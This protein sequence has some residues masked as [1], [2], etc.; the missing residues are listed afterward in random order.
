MN[1]IHGIRRRPRA[2]G[3]RGFTLVDSLCVVV[4]L[5]I[6]TSIMMPTLES[7]QVPTLE[8]AAR[9]LAADL[10]LARSQAIQFNT[11]WS[12]QFDL[13][14]NSYDLVHTGSG[15]PPPLRNPLTA[16]SDT[17]DV[18]H[19]EIG[20]RGFTGR[21]NL[22]ARLTSVTLDVSDDDVTEITFGPLGGTGPAR[23]EDTLIQLEVPAGRRS[24]VLQMR[25]SWVT[26]QVWIGE[27]MMRDNDA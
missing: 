24:R 20:H 16:A 13:A 5:A 15:A 26:G 4:I 17:S 14:E 12:M 7:T 27:V 19:V 8:S 11:T 9:V 21:N 23:A 18:Y 3:R 22:S 25:V 2:A 6:L 1:S 10:K